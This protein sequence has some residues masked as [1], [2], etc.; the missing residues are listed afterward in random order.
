MKFAI[1]CAFLLGMVGCDR[2]RSSTSE[3][4]ATIGM[5]RVDDQLAIGGGGPCGT[6]I[7]KAGQFC[8]NASCSTCAPLGGAC[9]QQVCNVTTKQLPGQ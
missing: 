7:C 1:V 3:P 9:T 2:A 6:K 8:C 5:S 4:A